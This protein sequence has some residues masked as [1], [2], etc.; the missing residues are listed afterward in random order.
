MSGDKQEIKAAKEDPV[1]EEKFK[2]LADDPY[3]YDACVISASISWMPEDGD[4]AGRQMVISVR[5]HLD[6]PI[7]RFYRENEL[8]FEQSLDVIGAM[9]QELETD[10]PNRK[11]A[12]LKAI[13]GKK[14]NKSKPASGSA[15][16]STSDGKVISTSTPIQVRKNGSKTTTEV[17]D[18]QQSLF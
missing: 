11:M 13:A 9:L 6:Q 10:M 4:P 5:N 15:V 1:V 7:M 2:A 16:S 12:K 18:V 8:P 3:T 14:K 17:L